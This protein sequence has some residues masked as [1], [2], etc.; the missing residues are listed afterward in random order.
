MELVVGA[1]GSLGGRIVR[2]LLDHGGPVRALVRDPSRGAGLEAAGANVVRGDLKDPPS[3]AAACRGVDVVISTASATRRTDDTPGNVDARGTM[4]LVDAAREAGVRRFIYVSTLGATPDSPVP[5]FRAK[6]AAEAHLGKSG[7]DYVILQPDAFMD[8]WFG[9]LIEGPVAAG[10]PV[11]LVGESKG[12]HSFI[13]EADLAKFAA[14][15]A[16]R[17]GTRNVTLALGG[18]EAITFADAVRAY[19]AALGRAIAIRS[20]PPGS[21]IPGLP[22]IVSD[23]AAAFESYD[24]IVPMQEM[25]ATFGVPLTTVR[26]FA[27]RRVAEGLGG[28]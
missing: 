4:N 21:T 9:M 22:E 17:A 12:R 13:A 14:G 26:D 18:P 27:K 2:E 15:A 11:T 28:P 6:A 8:V 10:L 3:L 7:M 24:S 1:T 19:G 23:I 25:S 16:R 5:A 20:V